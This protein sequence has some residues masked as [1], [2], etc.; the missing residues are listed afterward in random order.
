MICSIASASEG[1]LNDLD[2]KFFSGGGGTSGAAGEILGSADGISGG[3]RISSG[4]D[5]GAIDG[6]C[7]AV[8]GVLDCEAAGCCDEV[9]VLDAAGAGCDALMGG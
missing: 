4:T 2:V 8:W 9:G 5:C 3:S 1:R 6:A 7:V